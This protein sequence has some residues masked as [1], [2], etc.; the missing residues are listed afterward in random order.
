[1][2]HVSL[3]QCLSDLNGNQTVDNDDLLILLAQYGVHCSDIPWLDPVISEIHYNPS[4]QQGDDSAYEFIELMNPH[5]V[6]LNLS[7]W[8]LADGVDATFP[9]GTWVEAGGY[10]VTA[11]DT[12][13]YREMLGPFVQLIPWSGTSSLHNSGEAIRVVRPD[14]TLADLVTYSDTDGW[15]Q[16]ADGAGASLE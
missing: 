8:S 3:S 13:T 15:T 6:D 11:N 16:E 4:T 10:L 2:P 12:S 1:M 7:G 5:G 9:P 14:G